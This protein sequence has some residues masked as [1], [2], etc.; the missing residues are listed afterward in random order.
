MFL[1]SFYQYNTIQYSTTWNT[2][3]YNRE[4]I[5]KIHL[6]TAKACFHRRYRKSGSVKARQLIYRYSTNKIN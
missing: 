3:Q 2:I 1:A 5:V 6:A 4:F